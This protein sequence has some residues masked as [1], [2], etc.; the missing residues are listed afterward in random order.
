M[1]IDG[2]LVAGSF[3][4]LNNVDAA[5]FASTPISFVTNPGER[6]TNTFP[7]IGR[8]QSAHYVDIQVPA[9]FD[10]VQWT[11]YGPIMI[12]F[13]AFVMDMTNGI[14]N[15]LNQ[16]R[17]LLSPKLTAEGIKALGGKVLP[18]PPKAIFWG[19]QGFPPT[20]VFVKNVS[21]QVIE[22]KQTVS[23]GKP[24][25]ATV[26]VS[27]QVDTNSI[28]FRGALIYQAASAVVGSLLQL[29][30]SGQNFIREVLP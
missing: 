4:D 19:G 25:R 28:L 21:E 16:Y 2:F 22:I 12:S 24:M 29:K 14:E 11:G 7:E 5:S 3:K 6:R 18:P 9:G 27:L 15:T 8:S 1:A 30:D 20:E 13:Q 17:Q 10:G 23:G 26:T